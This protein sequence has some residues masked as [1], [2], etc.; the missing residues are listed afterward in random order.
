VWRCKGADRLC[1]RVAAVCDHDTVLGNRDT[2][3]KCDGT[4]IVHQDRSLTCSNSSCTVMAAVEAVTS[5]HQR[6]VACRQVFGEE[7]CPRCSS[8][9]FER[10]AT[11]TGQGGAVGE[12]ATLA[13]AWALRVDQE[14]GTKSS[15]ASPGPG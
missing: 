9:F 8:V 1:R 3:L 15:T 7:G 13:G 11:V 6:F 4:V 5:W 14:S 2:Y 10:S 12:P